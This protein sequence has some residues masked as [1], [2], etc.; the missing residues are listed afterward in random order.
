VGAIEL[1]SVARERTLGAAGEIAGEEPGFTSDV[2]QGDRLGKGG[3]YG[4]GVDDGGSG[5]G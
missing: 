2:G 3:E 1:L 4:G 5:D